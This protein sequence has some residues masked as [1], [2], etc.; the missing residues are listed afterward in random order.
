VALWLFYT[1]QVRLLGVELPSPSTAPSSARSSPEAP[2][3]PVSTPASSGKLG[4][5]AGA[6]GGWAAAGSSGRGAARSLGPSFGLSGRQLERKQSAS[7]PGQSPER[8]PAKFAKSAKM[9]LSAGLVTLTERLSEALSPTKADRQESGAGAWPDSPTAAD[10]AAAAAAGDGPYQ[11]PLH[12]GRRNTVMGFEQQ[13]Q[14]G[15]S[16]RQKASALV[17]PLRPGARAVSVSVPGADPTCFVSAGNSAAGASSGG[18]LQPVAEHS[19]SAW[20]PA[21]VRKSGAFG[22]LANTRASAAF[23]AG[24]GSL[25]VPLALQASFVQ[26]SRSQRLQ[27]RWLL[28]K[29]F[30]R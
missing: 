29:G 30:K 8:Q 18:G 14:A 21:G 26:A 9:L 6:S 2:E 10:T 12:A 13:Q 19:A 5:A 7:E 28:V 15:A 22:G 23:A 20:R 24:D 17:S 3:L 25:S 4:A 1:Q 27:R 11:W 16:L